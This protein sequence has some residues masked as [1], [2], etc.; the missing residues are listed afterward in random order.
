MITSWIT[1]A[2]VA[3]VTGFCNLLPTWGAFPDVSGLGSVVGSSAQLLNQWLPVSTMGA[4][5]G[6]LLAVRLSWGLWTLIVWVYHQIPVVG[7]SS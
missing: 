2:F 5:L 3:F 1:Q 7:G 4:A 6:V